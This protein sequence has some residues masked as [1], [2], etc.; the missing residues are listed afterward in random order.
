MNGQLLYCFK[1][2]KKWQCWITNSQYFYINADIHIFVKV[3][4]LF[5][6]F[7]SLNVELIQLIINLII[8]ITN[9][10][11]RSHRITWQVNGPQMVN[12][13]RFV[14]FN[15]FKSLIQ[16]LSQILMHW[17]QLMRF[18]GT[19]HANVLVLNNWNRKLK[20]L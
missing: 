1:Q 5:R 17:N 8:L 13:I 15:W 11:L 19:V 9:C 2:I 18:N 6:H 3:T 20:L 16:A 10:L 4:N 12:F 14:N 7:Q